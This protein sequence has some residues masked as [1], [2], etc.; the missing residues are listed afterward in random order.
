MK[1]VPILFGCVLVSV[2]AYFLINPQS[3]SSSGGM[4]EGEAIVSI[5]VPQSLSAKADMG[6]SRYDERC[7]ACHGPNAVGQNG[8]APPLV[9]KIY[10]PSHHGDESFQLAVLRGVRAHHWSFG[11][12]PPVEG[13]SRSDVELII[14]YIRELQVANGIN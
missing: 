7:L 8:V 5:D 1:L 12:M 13:L 6:K 11:D 14:T 10:E 4:T 2:A 9:H 3:G